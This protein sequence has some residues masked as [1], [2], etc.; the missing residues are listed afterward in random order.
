MLFDQASQYPLP[1]NAAINYVMKKI[2][3]ENAARVTG[4]KEA[5]LL[6]VCTKL[7]GTIVKQN[8]INMATV[9][10]FIEVA[11]T[12]RGLGNSEVIVKLESLLQ[13]T[14][15]QTPELEGIEKQ[16]RRLADGWSG[17]DDVE[18][19]EEILPDESPENSEAP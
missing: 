8:N 14:K 19:A 6:L 11:K 2:I 17:E 3:E 7:F 4:T 10:T 1:T 5:E 15:L 13:L 12:I 9:S 18:N 16:I